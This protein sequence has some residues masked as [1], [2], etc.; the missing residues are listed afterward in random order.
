MFPLYYADNCWRFVCRKKGQT[1]SPA[2]AHTPRIRVAWGRLAESNYINMNFQSNESMVTMLS[3]ILVRYCHAD[4]QFTQTATAR[5][6]EV[7]ARET[8]RARG[9]H[10]AHVAHGAHMN[11]RAH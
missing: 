6:P 3:C 10:G 7:Q 1:P 4:Y 8:H 9:E 2:A 5:L 11:P